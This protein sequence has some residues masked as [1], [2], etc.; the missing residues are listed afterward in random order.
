MALFPE[1]RPIL[2]FSLAPCYA[3]RLHFSGFICVD[4]P[5]IWSMVRYRMFYP[6]HERQARLLWNSPLRRTR[7]LSQA[8]PRAQTRLRTCDLFLPHPPPVLSSP[9]HSEA[10]RFRSGTYHRFARIPG[11]QCSP[12][13][14]KPLFFSF[15]SN[16]FPPFPSLTA[17][18]GSMP[19]SYR[20]HRPIRHNSFCVFLSFPPPAFWSTPFIS[21]Y[22][23]NAPPLFSDQYHIDFPSFPPSG[24]TDLFVL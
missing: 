7:D 4:C 15:S 2:F 23:P 24:K 1:S 19:D 9:I 14:F 18:I 10:V 11:A 13:T 5:V 16:L 3:R 8:S 20:V 22:I 17:T 6:Y 12:S 21:G